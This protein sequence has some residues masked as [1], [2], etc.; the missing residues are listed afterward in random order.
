MVT[1]TRHAAPPARPAA[2]VARAWQT[3]TVLSDLLGTVLVDRDDNTV[4]E[5]FSQVLCCGTGCRPG[6]HPGEMI[7]HQLALC[8][9]E[10]RASQRVVS[11]YGVR[12]QP[13]IILGRI[14]SSPGWRFPTSS[15]KTG[16]RRLEVLRGSPGY[17]A[18]Q[19]AKY[20]QAGR[21]GLH[22][23]RQGIGEE[24]RKSQHG[25]GTETLVGQELLV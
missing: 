10:R 17:R 6:S 25:V 11:I 9:I 24:C 7:V 2:S 3:R 22:P 8:V 20:C 19:R 18:R 12:S 13:M 1:V 21:S 14:N 16:F 23:A 4:R 5:G 15:V